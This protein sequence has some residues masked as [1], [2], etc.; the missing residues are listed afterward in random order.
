M[1]WGEQNSEAEAHAQLDYAVAQGINFIDTAEM[2]PV[3]PNATTQGRTE[4]Y[5]RQLARAP[6]PRGDLVIAT[7]V[8]GPGRRDWI[9]SGRTDL[10]ARRDRRGGRH[11]PRAA[12]DRLHR[13]VSRS[14]GRSATCRCS[15]QPSSIRRRSGGGPSIRE[16][17]EG[18]AA[19]IKAGKIRHYGLSNET[20]WGVCEF[21]RAARELGVP[22]PVTMQNSYSLVSRSVDNDLA[23]ALFREQHV[24]ARLQPARR[25]HAVRQVPRRRATRRRALRAVRSLG[26]RFRKP[27]VAEAVEAYAALAEA[28]RPHARAA[29]A[30]L[31]AQP[32]VLGAH[33]HRR[34]L[35]W[36]S[37]RRTS[38]PRS[39]SSTP[40]RWPRSPR[41]WCATR[42]RAELSVAQ[43]SVI[44][45]AAAPPVRRRRRG[46]HP[47]LPARAVEAV[48]PPETP[49]AGALGRDRGDR[50][51]GEPDRPDPGFHP[52]ARA[53]R[54]PD[55]DPA[56]HRARRCA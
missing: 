8:A 17:V 13:S 32:L 38:Q 51:C 3:P 29:R 12:A 47:R 42:T 30:R 20:A 4:K 33:D 21:Q 39:S 10:T 14:T 34:D 43:R 28:T 44:G 9:R 36:R 5:P 53:A 1:T 22:G 41:C 19:L 37:S 11:Q 26:V 18:M 48:P 52:G 2:Y 49:R 56:R 40:R 7:K 6:A 27:I 55:P 15:A 46:A 16:Q 23:E 25:R 45:C 35:A 50:L 31:R 24:A 54:R